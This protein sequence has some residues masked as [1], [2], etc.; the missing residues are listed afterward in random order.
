MPFL[1][2]AAALPAVGDELQLA[3]VL[4]AQADYDRVRLAA[5]QRLEDT[6][7]CVQSQAALLPVASLAVSFALPAA[8]L[9]A[10]FTFV[11]I[12]SFCQSSCRFL[13]SRYSAG[14]IP[15]SALKVRENCE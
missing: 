13:L 9:A 6:E 3:L 2:V 1:L 15:S 7:R 12:F 8:L 4:R 11:A 10:S 5:P 14:V